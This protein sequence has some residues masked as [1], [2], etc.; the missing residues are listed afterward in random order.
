MKQP[1]VLKSGNLFCLT[2]SVA[3]TTVCLEYT[4]GSMAGQRTSKTSLHLQLES[5]C[6]YIRIIKD[7]IFTL[8]LHL[9]L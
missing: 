5:A 8:L 1:C 2:G 3:A 9:V 4:E 7:L 6:G